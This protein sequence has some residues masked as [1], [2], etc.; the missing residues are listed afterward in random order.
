VSTHKCSLSEED[1][2]NLDLSKIKAGETFDFQLKK[3]GNIKSVE[4][5]EKVLSFKESI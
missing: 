1:F 2:K 4:E 5:L 3:Y